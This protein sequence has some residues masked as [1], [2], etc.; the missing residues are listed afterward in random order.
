LEHNPDSACSLLRIMDLTGAEKRDIPL[1]SCPG[2]AAFTPNGKWLY[3]S[4]RMRDN[5]QG[6]FRIRP[7][8]STV[9]PVVSWKN[10]EE[11]DIAFSDDGSS[12]AFTSNG[13]GRW[14]L[15]FS[16]AEG[17]KPVCL[18]D[19]TA[20]NIMPRFDPSGKTI[21]FL[22]DK[23]SLGGAREL[24]TYSFEQAVFQQQTK[25]GSVGDFC[26]VDRVTIVY[27]G[28]DTSRLFVKSIAPPSTVRLIPGVS[29]DY[30][31]ISPRFIGT[32]ASAR[33]LYTREYGD[34]TK[35][36]FSVKL[37]GSDDAA[38]VNSGGQDWLE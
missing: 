24:W 20:N 27:C 18:T 3:F 6:I 25:N 34:G 15:F 2:R 12:M 28:G 22:S 4:A 13:N 14:Q 11:N 9:T 17:F 19:G 32:G 37:D 33:I 29:G 5:S 1:V 30:R 10:A 23:T 8:G 26:W 36:I 31:E 21:A 35:R 38:V 16:N 7:D